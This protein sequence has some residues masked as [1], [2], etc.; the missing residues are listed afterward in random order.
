MGPPACPH[1]QDPPRCPAHLQERPHLRNPADH[2][3]SPHPPDCP[4]ANCPRDPHPHCPGCFPSCC[5]PCPRCLPC[6]S[7]CSCCCPSYRCL[8]SIPSAD[9]YLKD[10]QRE[11]CTILCA[12]S[13]FLRHTRLYSRKVG[14]SRWLFLVFLR[15]TSNVSVLLQYVVT[16]SRTSGIFLLL[17]VLYVRY[18][19]ELF[20]NKSVL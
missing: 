11:N 8:S 19:R 18:R 3:T 17:N 1:C 15:T 2:W 20:I 16:T 4:P 5:Y 13:D 10:N 12:V 9:Q 6:P 14:V 7:C